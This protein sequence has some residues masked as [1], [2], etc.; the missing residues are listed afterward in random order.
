MTWRPLQLACTSRPAALCLQRWHTL[1]M[2]RGGAGKAT[3]WSPFKAA[4]GRE[5]YRAKSAASKTG[6]LNIVEQHPG[7]FYPKRKLDGEKG[8]KKMKV[9]GAASPTAW[10]AA[11]KLAEFLDAPYE[12]PSREP[13]PVPQPLKD[14]EGMLTEA[15]HKR[16]K[17]L[18]Q[19]AN[20][21]LDLDDDHELEPVHVDDLPKLY[22]PGEGFVP[23]VEAIA[24]PTRP[25]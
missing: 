23:M 20:S 12:L 25:I 22:V 9:F 4:D 18:S 2:P 1:A 15:G 3:G 7:K 8:S 10:E 17:A 6:Y 21:L 13:R 5:L 24:C 11:N 16:L 14:S 19:E